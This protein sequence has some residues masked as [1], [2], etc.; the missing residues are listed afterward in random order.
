MKL[1]A[2]LVRQGFIKAMAQSG[3]YRKKARSVYTVTVRSIN[4]HYTDHNKE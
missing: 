4:H 1:L 3:D 2:F